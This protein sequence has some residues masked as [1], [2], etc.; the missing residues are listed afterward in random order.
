MKNR[1]K[2][3][4]IIAVFI[5]ILLILKAVFLCF[6][7]K[8]KEL[9]HDFFCENPSI[10]TKEDI[11]KILASFPDIHYTALNEEYLNFTKS[12]TGKYKRILRNSSFKVL[13]QEDF[14]KKIV[15]QYRVRE[16]LCQDKYYRQA[17]LNPQAEFYWLID[18]KLLYAVLELQQILGE[19]GFDPNAMTINYGHRHPRKNEEA[20]G[21]GSSK[22]IKGQAVDLIIGDI[23]KDGAYTDRD[24]EIVLEIVDKKVI[25]NRGGVGR[26]PGSKIVHIDVRGKRARWDSY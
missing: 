12:D 4:L 15:G 3:K 20:G 1:L 11:D 16:F 24:K 8:G 6:T 21:A 25:G 10:H 9:Y 14:F 13:K 18:K 17:L 26:Y 19:K 7:E 23:N 5:G 22:H 2:F